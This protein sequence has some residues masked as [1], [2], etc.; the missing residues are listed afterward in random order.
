VSISKMIKT[1][2]FT[3]LSRS[4]VNVLIKCEGGELIIDKRL[5]YKGEDNREGKTTHLHITIDE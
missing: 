1:Q 4:V 2:Y 5:T 3:V